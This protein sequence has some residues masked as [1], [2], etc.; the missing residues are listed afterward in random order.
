MQLMPLH[1]K[2][3]YLGI[4]LLD[5]RA[6]FD[7]VDHSILLAHLERSYGIMGS[8]LSWLA[9][10]LD[11]RCQTVAFGSSCLASV[12]MKQGFVLG[13]LLFLL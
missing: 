13:P 11:A 7:A 9:S 10:F 8:A 6:A 12:R 5:L 2:S 1:P 4:G 3:H